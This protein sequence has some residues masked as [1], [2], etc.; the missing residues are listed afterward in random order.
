[1]DP[2]VVCEIS[3]DKGHALLLISYLYLIQFLA[4]KKNSVIACLQNRNA[5]KDHISL[6]V[7]EKQDA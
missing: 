5:L 6:L 7:V 2:W 1:M 3:E 4:V